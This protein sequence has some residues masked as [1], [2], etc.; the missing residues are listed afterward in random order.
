MF[1]FAQIDVSIEEA[2]RIS[3]RDE[4]KPKLNE[5]FMNCVSIEHRFFKKTLKEKER[6]LCRLNKL[7]V[8][9]GAANTVLLA[10]DY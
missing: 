10:R 1:F 5:L 6:A 4:L 2:T 3:T 9:G 7:M 8:N